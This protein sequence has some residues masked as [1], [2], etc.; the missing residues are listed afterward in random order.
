MRD[1]LVIAEALID[2]DESGVEKKERRPYVFRGRDFRDSKRA[3]NGRGRPWP[4][5]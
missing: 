5:P 3:R 1:E 2:A 4:L